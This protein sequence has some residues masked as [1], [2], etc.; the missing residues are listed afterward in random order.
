MAKASPARRNFNG[1]EWSILVEGRTDIDKYSASMRRVVNAIAATQ[2]P[3][4]GRSG[5][6]FICTAYDRTKYSTLIP[7]NFNEDETLQLE[8]SNGKLRFIFETGLQTYAPVAITGV[9]NVFPFTFTAT[10]L[11]AVAGSQV[12]LNGLPNDYNANGVVAN[13]IQVVGDVHVTDIDAGGVIGAVPG[14]TASLVYTIDTPYTDVLARNIRA[15]QDED[16]VYLFCKGYQPRQL[17]RMSDYNWVLSL[18]EF[19]NGPFLNNDPELGRLQI[20]A[21]GR[22]ATATQFADSVEGAPALPGGY[23]PTY[24]TASA[25]FDAVVTTSWPGDSIQGGLLG[26]SFAAPRIITGYVIYPSYVN[27]APGNAAEDFA[28]ASWVFQGSLDGVTY[29]TLDTQKDY[30]LYEDGRSVWFTFQNTVA[31]SYYRIVISQLVGNG[32]LKPRIAELVFSDKTPPTINVTLSGTTTLNNGVGFVA[33]DVGRLLRVKGS[34]GH[35][36]VL[37]ITGYTSATLVATQ[38][39]SEPFMDTAIISEWAP[40]YYSNTTGWPTCGTFFD[41]RLCVAGSTAHPGLVSCSRVG[42]YNDFQQKTSTDVVLDDA[43]LV[44]KVKSRKVSDIRWI[45][46]DER[47]LILGTGVGINTVSPNNPDLALTA[48]TAKGRNGPA[49]GT[50]FAEPVK[51]D[52]RILHIHVSRRSIREVSYDFSQTDSYSSRSLSLFASHLGIPQFAQMVYAAEPHSIIWYRRD[53]GSMVGF[54]YNKDEDVLGW[55]THDFS[56][57]IESLSV[58]PSPTDKQDVLWM[59]IKR[60]IDGVEQRYIEKLTRFFDFDST[61]DNM[62]YV[63]SGLRYSGAATDVLYGL[64]H[65]EGKTVSGVFNGVPFTDLVVTNGQLVC[66]IEDVVTAVVGLPYEQF[67]EISRIE[68]GAADGTAQGKVKRAN[69]LSVHLWQ[70]AGGE[71]AVFDEEEQEYKWEDIAYR[72]PFDEL[73][74]TTLVTE[75]LKPITMPPGYGLGGTIAF[76]QRLPLP[77]NI[78][79]L[80]PQLNTQDR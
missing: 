40:G 48:R 77:L 46:S 69:S 35:Y 13:I 2:G 61:V 44:L 56:G 67:G 26:A 9:T 3:F 1:G 45:E 12:A 22:A 71:M 7:F 59:A 29:V 55:H 37:K 5:T 11:G 6:M 10:G 50:A 23:L 57:E 16:T 25:A 43:A 19:N 24:G 80:Y 63:D 17:S 28:P 15:V 38:L 65:L 76:R 72:E 14:A 27:T 53:D 66:P 51:V 54:T 49:R 30:I 39:L 52:N 33:T 73:A 70:T 68:A 60:T 64:R 21:T 47:G 42:S 8:F 41:D 34:D 58:S 78:I 32:S 75:M 31:Y 4:I 36:R 79:A 74:T 20:S 18:F 62:Q